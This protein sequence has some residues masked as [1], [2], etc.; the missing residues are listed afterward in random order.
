MRVFGFGPR[1]D[2][3]DRVCREVSTTIALWHVPYFT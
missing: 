3:C 2:D 1:R